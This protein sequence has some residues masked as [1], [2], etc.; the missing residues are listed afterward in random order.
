MAVIVLGGGAT[1]GAAFVDS[2]ADRPI[3]LPPLDGDFFTQ[4]QRV[5][6]PKHKDRIDGVLNDVVEL[7]GYNFRVTLETMFTTIEHTLRVVNATKG[8]AG[9]NPDELERKRVR[10]KQ[11]IAAVLEESLTVS[12]VAGRR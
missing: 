2:D 10:L 11:A 8:S 6:N 12:A 4:L 3:C 1:R 5:A 9:W 7:F